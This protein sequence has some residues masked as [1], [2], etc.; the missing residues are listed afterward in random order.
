MSIS[1]S[2][3][4]ASCEFDWRACSRNYLSYFLEKAVLIFDVFKS[5]TG[6]VFAI[7]SVD[8]LSKGINASY[9]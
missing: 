3:S 5:D 6:L 9:G 4:S 1:L 7:L 8:F 2:H